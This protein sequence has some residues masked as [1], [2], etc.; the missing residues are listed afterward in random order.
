MGSYGHFIHLWLKFLHMCN[1]MYI[2]LPSI[3]WRYIDFWNN[4][5][6]WDGIIYLFINEHWMTR[7]RNMNQTLVTKYPDYD[8]CHTIQINWPISFEL[9]RK[10]GLS[11]NHICTRIFISYLSGLFRNWRDIIYIM[12]C[13]I[14][15]CRMFGKIPKNKSFS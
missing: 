10:F 3:G 15:S 2:S 12:M 11:F 6:K 1:R 5:D 13:V 14:I 4:R 9:Y 8:V 7:K